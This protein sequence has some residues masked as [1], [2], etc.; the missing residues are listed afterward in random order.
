M[1]DMEVEMVNREVEMTG[2]AKHSG[3]KKV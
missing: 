3:R 2:R 1:T